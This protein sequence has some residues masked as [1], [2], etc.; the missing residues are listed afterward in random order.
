MSI[1][2]FVC[3]FANVDQEHTKEVCLVN[4][5][6]ML[7]LTLTLMQI[8]MQIQIQ[9]QMEQW[10][11]QIQLVRLR[12]L[13]VKPT[14]WLTANESTH[15]LDWRLRTTQIVHN[16]LR[17][18]QFYSR[19]IIRLRAATII[20]YPSLESVINCC[21]CNCSFTFPSCSCTLVT[22]HQQSIRWD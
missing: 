4:L 16:N 1:C 5:L 6:K 21:C 2:L 8:Q 11:E 19:Q 22:Q 15:E 10:L 3:A 20:S 9:I 12:C 18:K 17:R 14:N 13:H 7:M